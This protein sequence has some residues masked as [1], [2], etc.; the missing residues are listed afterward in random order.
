MEKKLDEHIKLIVDGIKDIEIRH[1]GLLTGDLGSLLLCFEYFR[2]TG[3]QNVLNFAMDELR[4]LR[5]NNIKCSNF[6]Q[7]IAGMG[8]L[9]NYFYRFGYLGKDSMSW[10]PFVDCFLAKWML[11]EVDN[12]NYDFLYGAGGVA[13]YFINRLQNKETEIYLEQFVNLLCKKCIDNKDGS[14]KWISTLDDKKTKRGYNIGLSHGIASIINILCKIYLNDICP[15]QCKE[16][17]IGAISY[18]RK[19]KLPEGL[20]NSLFSNWALEST[21]QLCGSRLAWCY[22]DLGIA[23]TFWN[24]SQILNDKDLEK[25]SIE[26]LIHSSKRKDLTKNFVS[27]AGICHGTSGISH[28]FRRMYFNTNILEFNDTANYWIGKTLELTKLDNGFAE[29]KVWYQTNNRGSK[30]FLGLLEGVSGIGLALLSNISKDT[31]IWD[32]CLLLG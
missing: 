12:D 22:G 19:Q 13:F 14:K 29:Y 4:L 20:Y 11:E 3:N 18:V 9:L 21:N 17:I 5:F 25:E 7:G 32:E 1:M 8:W 6:S 23:V 24:A 27:D 26:I 28:I 10:M 31:P 15:N 16:L 30:P 2:I